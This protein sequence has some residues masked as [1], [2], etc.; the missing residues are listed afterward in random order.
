MIKKKLLNK[1]IDIKNIANINLLNCHNVLFSK[2]GI[3]KNYGCY[4]ILFI[5]LLH[6][7]LIVIFFTKN[8]FKNLKEKIEEIA[9][10]INNKHLI[11]NEKEKNIEKNKEDI[12]QKNENIKEIKEK[13]IQTIIENKDIISENRA[14]LIKNKPIKKKKKKKK[15]LINNNS[16][17]INNTTSIIKIKKNADSLANNETNID[18][19]VKKLSKNEKLLSKVK[20]IMSYNDK[21]LNNLNY[22]LAKKYDKRTYFQYYLSLLKTKHPILFTFFINNDYNLIIIKIDFFFFGF[23]YISQLMLYFSMIIQCIKYMKIKVHIILFI[24]YRK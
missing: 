17:K 2:K 16:I 6:I 23:Y 21:E 10:G 4:L 22:E 13:E 15:K 12:T 18:N 14:K 9:F 24:K 8:A 11:D 5:L 19:G 3:K 1:F 7:I 20:K